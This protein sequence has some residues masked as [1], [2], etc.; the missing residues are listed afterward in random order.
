M[1]NDKMPLQKKVLQLTLNNYDEPL[2]CIEFFLTK[3]ILIKF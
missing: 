3:K 1:K 2:N